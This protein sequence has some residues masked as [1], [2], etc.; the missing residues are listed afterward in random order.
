M[1]KKNHKD[2][3]DHIHEPQLLK[4]PHVRL[5]KNLLRGSKFQLFHLLYSQTL[6]VY[7]KQRSENHGYWTKQT[8]LP[9]MN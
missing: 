5:A 7:A 2:E 1:L 9:G 6:V 8:G 4:L 3:Q